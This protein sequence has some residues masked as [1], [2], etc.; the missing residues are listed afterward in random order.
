[1]NTSH[2]HNRVHAIVEP[3]NG[4]DQNAAESEKSKQRD[5]HWRMFR[6]VE[7]FTAAGSK[8]LILSCCLAHHRAG[9]V[10]CREN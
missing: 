3:A 5:S 2:V 1:M 9:V 6:M 10:T 7:Y 4:I 8:G